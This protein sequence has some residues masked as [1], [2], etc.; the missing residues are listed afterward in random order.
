MINK[1]TLYPKT[2]RVTKNSAKTI[3]TEK[4]DGSN[5]GFAKVD[6]ELYVVTR[7]NIY[8]AS[9]RHEKEI[10]QRMYKGLW[11]FLEEFGEQLKQDLVDNALI[12]G[13]WIAMGRLK[14]PESYHLQFHMF[15]KANVDDEFENVTNMIYDSEHFKY[16]FVKQFVP[17][18][19]ETVPKV[20]TFNH[21]P[22]IEE[23]DELYDHYVYDMNRDVEGFILN[24]NN[25]VLKYVRNK[26]GKIEDHVESYK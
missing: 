22:S 11:S 25:Q 21:Y 15:A 7:N 18:Y 26:N 24:Q 3:V 5:L 10:K 16:S 1:R 14:Y 23:L 4:L 20:C 19:L 9:D 8:K 17:I 13:E 2:K 12:F 6:G